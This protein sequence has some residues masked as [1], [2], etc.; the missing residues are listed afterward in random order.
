[1]STT[2]STPL[3]QRGRTPDIFLFP[4]V[5]I[6]N[7]ATVLISTLIVLDVATEV[8]DYHQSIA[9]SPHYN[10][11]KK[12]QQRACKV[13]NIATLQVVLISL[14]LIYASTHLVTVLTIN[15]GIDGRMIYVLEGISRLEASHLM[16][17]ISTKTPRWIGVYHSPSVERQ[18]KHVAAGRQQE[19]KQQG[20]KQGAKQEQ[21]AKGKVNNDEDTDDD[22]EF[23]ALKFHVRYTIAQYFLLVYCVCLPFSGHFLSTILGF[24]LGFGIESIIL[25][26]RRG[27][28][29]SDD[30]N[31]ST[32]DSSSSERKFSIAWIA[33]LIFAF[34]ASVMFA[35]GCHY[36]Q[37]VW[38]SGLLF[39]EWGLGIATFSSSM[40]VILCVHF[41]HLQRTI[42]KYY[43]DRRISTHETMER[44]AITLLQSHLLKKVGSSSSSFTSMMLSETQRALLLEELARLDS[45]KSAVDD[46]SPAISSSSNDDTTSNTTSSRKTATTTTTTT[47]WS[48]LK[49]RLFSPTDLVVFSRVEYYLGVF[50]SLASLFVVIVNIGATYQ[51]N[52]VRKNFHRVHETLYGQINEGPVCAWDK[53]GGNIDTFS[54]KE[55]A[56]KAGY[57]IAHCGACGQCSSWHDLRL[58]YT[59]RK[60]LAKEAFRCARKSMVYGRNAVHQCLQEEPIGFS[61][62]CAMCWTKDILC[63]RANCAFIFL[64]SHMINT[65]SNFQVGPETITSAT[66]EEAMC[67]LDFVPCSGAN[68]RRMNITSTILRPGDQRCGIVDVDWEEIFGEGGSL[69]DVGSILGGDSGGGEGESNDEL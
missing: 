31:D 65:F 13:V 10:K 2:Y 52:I 43:V 40:A 39:S 26:A 36:I 15:A 14:I 18:L 12:K 41:Y 25:F 44:T 56:L 28:V 47:W 9:R 37:V 33:S 60:Y 19:Q 62:N 7:W 22:D 27:G 35:D 11:D 3:F 23:R 59:T 64:Q 48:L 46:D 68:R 4:Q 38:G 5:P 58:Q 67:E 24:I 6:L 32:D 53:L 63:T 69:H 54:S 16:A 66:C 30:T 55:D 1:M 29:R 17:Y 45:E 42:Q 20:G 21:D 50:I 57:T 34:L 49:M 51:M 8:V 61:E